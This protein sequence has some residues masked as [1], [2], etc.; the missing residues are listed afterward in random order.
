[1]HY[2]S[3]DGHPTLQRRKFLGKKLQKVRKGIRN[4]ECTFQSS[5]EV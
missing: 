1:M 2:P 5:E 3:R 4:L